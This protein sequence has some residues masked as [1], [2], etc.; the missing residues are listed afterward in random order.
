MF[1][2]TGIDEF[3]KEIAKFEERLDKLSEK[4]SIKFSEMFTSEF[5]SQYTDFATLDE[6]LD[7]FGYADFSQEEF[8]AIPDDEINAK[9]ASHTKFSTFQEMLDKGCEL[10]SSTLSEPMISFASLS[11][12]SKRLTFSSASSRAL[13]STFIVSGFILLTSLS[14]I[15]IIAPFLLQVNNFI[16]LN[17][18]FYS[19][20]LP[21]A[22]VL[23]A[24]LLLFCHSA[25]KFC[26][27]E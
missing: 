23:I 16:A 8:E 18:L 27:D 22:F 11:K 12:E 5:M 19:Q 7:N 17:L 15:F 3:Q 20:S 6:M 9:V 2:I 13:V 14:V 10:Y 26:V 1:E 21:L 4:T 24:Q 25:N